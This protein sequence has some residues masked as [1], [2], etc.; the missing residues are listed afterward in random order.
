MGGRTL[1]SASR[2]MFIAAGGRDQLS[3]PQFVGQSK[4]SQEAGSVMGKSR[5]SMPRLGTNPGSATD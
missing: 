3:R 2:P 4:I 5:G 1:A